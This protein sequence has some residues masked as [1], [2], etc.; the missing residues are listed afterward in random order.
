[1]ATSRETCVS[2]QDP[3]I[4]TR[5]RLELVREQGPPYDEPQLC[6][7]PESAARFLAELVRPFAYEVMGIVNLVAAAVPGLGPD[8]IALV[9]TKGD[10][11][12]RPRPTDVDGDGITAAD[13]DQLEA[14]R[15]VEQELEAGQVR[16]HVTVRRRDD[17]R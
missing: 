5:F 15:K 1:M 16:H 12:H 2:S 8:S 6:S 9:T 11:L 14:T 13:T 3:T 4:A 17:A 7:R 10:M